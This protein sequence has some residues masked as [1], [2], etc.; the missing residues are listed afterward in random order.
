MFESVLQTIKLIIMRTKPF[1]T[2]VE[3]KAYDYLEKELCLKYTTLRHYHF[4][5][6]PVEDYMKAHQLSVLTPSICREALIS[7]Y[8][9]RS[10]DDLTIDEK[11]KE[12]AI[13]VLLEYLET[14][15]VVPKTKFRY[16]SGKI[17]NLIK[18]F[19]TH[20][21][22]NYIKKDTLEKN[23]S[24]LGIFNLYLHRKGID[25]I[26]EITR[27]VI[28]NFVISLDSAHKAKNHDILMVIRQLLEFAYYETKSKSNLSSLVPNSK[29]T[30][31][32]QLPAYYSEDEITQLC[33][34]I[35]RGS[36]VGKRD[37]AIF[38]I[39]IRT[40]LRASDIANLKF[41]NLDWDK[42]TIS[43][44][45][46]K[47][48]KSIILPLLADVGNAI[49]DYVQFG[50]PTSDEQYI[51]LK[52]TY[53]YEP[54]SA[55]SLCTMAHRRFT[56]SGISLS[57]RRHGVHSLRFSFVK[58]LLNDEVSIPVISESLGHKSVESTQHYISI[59]TNGLAQ[60][61]LPVPIVSDEFY[62]QKGGLYK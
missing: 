41:S 36:A 21:Q 30:K 8:N 14:G 60:C 27:V 11:Y 23:E 26:H 19:I 22:N 16:I 38:L 46:Y 4:R 20:R 31:G 61:S 28:N 24:L 56:E 9:G 58:R 25:D 33:D 15:K 47:T 43:L 37:Y 50:R 29:Y 55:R 53:P 32:S 42:C 59:D 1:F 34:S 2:D 44:S 40:A 45:Q 5:W 12:K 57:G 35:D 7:F 3:K 6:H 49:L 18:D 48:G 52:A 17:G 51:F 54:L 10:H 13:L 62:N 39:A